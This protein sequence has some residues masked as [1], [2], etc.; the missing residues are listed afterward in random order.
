MLIF[1]FFSCCQDGNN[2][3]SAKTLKKLKIKTTTDGSTLGLSFKKFGVQKT[4]LN[5]DSTL[6][7]EKSL[8]YCY[9]CRFWTLS[10]NALGRK[11]HR[12]SPPLLK[13]PRNRPRFIGSLY[14]HFETNAN[15]NQAS[16]CFDP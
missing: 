13:T 4:L 12:V 1:L 9:E 5:G 10:V 16:G 14:R 7:L 3:I 6:G 8:K 2:T 11:L 15:A